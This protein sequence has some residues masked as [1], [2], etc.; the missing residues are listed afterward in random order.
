MPQDRTDH[1]K[2]LK[3]PAWESESRA[4]R[5][6]YFQLSA[7]PNRRTSPKPLKSFEN[8]VFGSTLYCV[9]GWNPVCYITADFDV[10]TKIKPRQH[11]G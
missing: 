4:P 7:G 8:S 2:S 5:G 1:G 10:L 11:D 6:Q 9:A 3:N